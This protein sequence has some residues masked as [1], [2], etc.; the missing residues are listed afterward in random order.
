MGVHAQKPKGHGK[1][2]DDAHGFRVTLQTIVMSNK[3]SAIYG[4]VFRDCVVPSGRYFL[5]DFFN[6]EV[7]NVTLSDCHLEDTNVLGKSIVIGCS[8]TNCTL[9]PET[10]VISRRTLNTTQAAAR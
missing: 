1:D 7:H 10:I 5:C 9:S 8:V 6:C 3:S 2:D 4:Q